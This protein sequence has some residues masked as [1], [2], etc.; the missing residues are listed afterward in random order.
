ML[1]AY[2][3][4]VSNVSEVCCKYFV[5]ML[6]KYISMLHM[7]QWLFSMFQASIPNVSSV[8]R[9]VL[10]VCLS[11]CCICITHML[12]V[13]YLDVQGYPSLLGVLY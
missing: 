9:P 2:V 3:S 5:W 13:F 11:R 8:F 6:Q 10:Q 1:Q 4:S 7:L 12:Q